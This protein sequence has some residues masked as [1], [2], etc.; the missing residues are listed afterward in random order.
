MTAIRRLS[1]SFMVSISLPVSHSKSCS[2]LSHAC[3]RNEM[4]FPASEA[5]SQGVKEGAPRAA[6]GAPEPTSGTSKRARRGHDRRRRSG[7]PEAPWPGYRPE[8]DG[9]SVCASSMGL[10]TLH[11]VSVALGK[12]SA[13]INASGAVVDCVAFRRSRPIR[14]ASSSASRSCFA[15]NRASSVSTTSASRTCSRAR[16]RIVVYGQYREYQ[17]CFSDGDAMP[18]RDRPPCFG[19]RRIP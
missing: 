4:A 7:R 13:A 6:F 16:A 14:R 5:T 1:P 11:G 2:T 9:G 12:R 15:A 3:V 18:P 8:L 10:P 17:P 19:Q